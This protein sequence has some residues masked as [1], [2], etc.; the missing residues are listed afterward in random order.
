L[1]F[2]NHLA[3]G[4]LADL[5]QFG[6]K[7]QS[8]EV[9]EVI[10]DKKLITVENIWDLFA[11]WRQYPSETLKAICYEFIDANATDILQDECTL[12]T[13]MDYVKDIIGRNTL[14]AE[15]SA[16]FEFILQW[17]QMN[18]TENHVQL[19]SNMKLGK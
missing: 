2:P 10:S 11:I 5:L 19:L 14:R 8:D 3:F 16:I 6:F 12:T 17:I 15:K 13:P 7:E 1:S 4:L 9:V 18:P